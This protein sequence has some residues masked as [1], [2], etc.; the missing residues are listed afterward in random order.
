MLKNIKIKTCDSV[1]Y[2]MEDSYLLAEQVE[3]F[4][5]G[6]VL[7]M[8]TGSGINGIAAALKGCDVTF[9]DISDKAIRCAKEN[10][11][12]NGVYG[13]FVKTDMF[14]GIDGKFN[15]II[16]N[17]PYLDSKKAPEKDIALDGGKGGREIIEKFLHAY[18]KFAE[19]KHTVLLLES[20]INNYEEDVKRLKAEVVAKEYF[21]F[22][23]IAVLKISSD[24]Y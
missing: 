17:P 9:T 12:L 20:S 3:R 7:D 19:R 11:K 5:F 23:E 21:F 1:Y 4:A 16:F 2:P 24:I 6:K 18:P 10:A 8:G 22:E 15:T 14:D 13:T